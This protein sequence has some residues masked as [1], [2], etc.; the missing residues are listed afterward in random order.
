[1]K[2]LSD[3]AFRLNGCHLAVGGKELIMSVKNRFTKEHISMSEIASLEVASVESIH[4]FGGALTLGMVG[5]LALGPVGLLAGL[6]TGGRGHDTTFI[7]K[8]KDGRSFMATTST[9]AY[10]QIRG[11]TLGVAA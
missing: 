8:L 4:R 10:N 11:A 1:M 2:M 7:C 6:F 9:S 5:G 3:G